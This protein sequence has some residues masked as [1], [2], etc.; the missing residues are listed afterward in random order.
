MWLASTSGSLESLV[1]PPTN[2]VVCVTRLKQ[3]LALCHLKQKHCFSN[4]DSGESWSFGTNHLL[5]YSTLVTMLY[6]SSFPVI[7]KKKPNKQ[8]QQK[9]CDDSEFRNYF[10]NTY[11]TLLCESI[12][13]T[14]MWNERNAL[15]RVKQPHLTASLT[16]LWQVQ[17]YFSTFLARFFEMEFIRVILLFFNCTYNSFSQSVA[18]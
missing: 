11:K 17:V 6:S 15:S 3:N 14:K 8:Q 1:A 2:W 13:P 16:V 12:F 4:K 5:H 9:T 10:S 7:K 18:L